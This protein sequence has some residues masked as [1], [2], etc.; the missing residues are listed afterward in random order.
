MATDATQAMEVT[1]AMQTLKWMDEERLK[2]KALIA[3]LQER[4]QGQ[5]LQLA[6]QAAQLQEVQTTLAGIQGVLSKVI[7]FE[8][9]V[10]NYKDEMILQMDQREEAW[11]KE[12]AE[13]KRLRQIEY[14]ALTGSL[15]RMEKDLRPLSQHE[16]ELT[17]QRA[18]NQRLSKTLQQMEVAVG[19]LSQRSDDRV[20][21]V[22]YLEEQRRADNRRISDLE[23]DTTELYKRTETQASKLS[24]LGETLQ[25]QRTRIEEAI[26]E[27]KKF[28]KPLEELRISDFQREQKMKQYMDQGEQV[29]QEM[30]RM[31]TQTQGFIEQQQQV[32]RATDKLEGFQARLARRQNEVAEM[33]RVAEDRLR[34]QW[35]EWQ[36]ER[37][38]QQ[39]KRNVVI[40]ERW[41]RQ[42]Q[43]NAEHREHLD[44]LQTTA[45]LHRDQLDALWEA[46]RTNSARALKRIQDDHEALSAQADEQQST[47]RG[48]H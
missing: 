27:T 10:S 17:A 39:K 25:K 15:N 2:D 23:H 18:E 26:Q 32:K 8:Q 22:T 20:K 41:R 3:A 38:K 24:L 6:Q 4:V 16:E 12:Q 30:E 13:A 34:R 11:R 44:R 1:Q 48:E 21:A 46:R 47:L 31:Q 33:Q 9:M 5:E 36:D 42:E 35:E 43:T 40:E 29:A 19:D 7:E 28:E 45:D 14:E 37:A